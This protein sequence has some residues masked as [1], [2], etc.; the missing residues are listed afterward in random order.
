M[1]KQIPNPT[2]TLDLTDVQLA[3]DVSAFDD[4]IRNFGVSMVHYAAMRCPV[5]MVSGDDGRRPGHHH[6]NCVNG[7][8]LTRRG[9]VTVATQGNS[10]GI[11]DLDV[12][13]VDGSTIQA[14]FPRFYDDRPEKHLEIMVYDRFYYKEEIEPVPTE[15]TFASSLDGVDRLRFPAV[16][17]SELMDSA[18]KSYVQNDDFTIEDGAI[19]WTG[20]GPG[21][22][23]STGTGKVITIRYC[24]KPYYVVSRLIHEV[25][26][27]H[28]IGPEG[29]QVVRMPQSALLQR[30]YFFQSSQV[31]PQ[32][33]SN[34]Q[35]E[36]A[37]KANLFGAR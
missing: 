27:A 31:D 19:K 35:E 7:F 3:F 25:R 20:A 28:V 15:E 11:K 8:I 14:V 24:Y 16:K 21:M 17:V 9:E 13:L 2:L 30:E 1:P 22:E 18:G 4:H 10:H 12:G 26:V 29:R 5:G 6:I 34:R 37:H 33:P 23:P 32:V 36:K